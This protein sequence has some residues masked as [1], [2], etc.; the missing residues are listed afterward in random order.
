[1]IRLR[2]I[3]LGPLVQNTF[4]M[5]YDIV[6]A[7]LSVWHLPCSSTCLPFLLALPCTS[8]DIYHGPPILIEHDHG[9]SHPSKEKVKSSLEK[10]PPVTGFKVKIILLSNEALEMMDSRCRLLMT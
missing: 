8:T 6:L 10:P 4:A 2:L 7:Y 5:F 3:F 9:L 1:L